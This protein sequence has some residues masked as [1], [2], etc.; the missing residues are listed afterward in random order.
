MD[1]T[2][3]ANIKSDIFADFVFFVIFEMLKTLYA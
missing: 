1:A 3:D 2:D